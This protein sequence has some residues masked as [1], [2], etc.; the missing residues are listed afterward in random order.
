MFVYDE[1][2]LDEIDP[3][4]YF[5]DPPVVPDEED[6]WDDDEYDDKVS[7]PWPDCMEQDFD[8]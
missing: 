6:W 3:D 7:N 8:R 2:P 5:D 1:S 4:D